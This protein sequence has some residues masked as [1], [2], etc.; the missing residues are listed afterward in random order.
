MKF[1]VPPDRQ[2]SP[3]TCF[4]CKD[5]PSVGSVG[6]GKNAFF[7]VGCVLGITFQGSKWCHRPEFSPAERFR[8]TKEITQAWAGWLGRLGPTDLESLGNSLG[9]GVV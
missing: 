8:V 3:H 1:R 2:A 6:L 7:H 4:S 5:F 9:A